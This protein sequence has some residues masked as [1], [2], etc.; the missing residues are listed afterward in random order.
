MLELN[1]VEMRGRLKKVQKVGQKDLVSRNIRK[2]KACE[3]LQTTP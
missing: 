1:V 2:I 3:A